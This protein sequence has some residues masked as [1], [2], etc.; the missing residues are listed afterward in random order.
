MDLSV[1]GNRYHYK[2]TSPPKMDSQNEGRGE[3]HND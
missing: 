2:K 3:E 1:L